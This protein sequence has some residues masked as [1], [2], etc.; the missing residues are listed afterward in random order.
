MHFQFRH[1][2]H[3][4]MI[5]KHQEIRGPRYPL[6]HKPHW[7]S[8]R[9]RMQKKHFWQQNMI[10]KIFSLLF[11]IVQNYHRQWS[12]GQKKWDVSPWTTNRK[13]QTGTC[14]FL[15]ICCRWSRQH[16]EFRQVLLLCCNTRPICVRS[17]ISSHMNT[18]DL[19]DIIL[20]IWKCNTGCKA[21]K[22]YI[23]S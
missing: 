20:R 10:S 7:H 19:V 11:T 6:L 12:P 5:W 2:Y 13:C 16:T 9:R 23:A 22:S 15:Q 17:W 4:I 3:K 1:A 21:S 8:Q 18:K 14:R